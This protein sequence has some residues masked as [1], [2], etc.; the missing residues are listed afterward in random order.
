MQE[1]PTIKYLPGLE[2]LENKQL[3]STSHAARPLGKTALGWARRDPARTT[4]RVVR[5]LP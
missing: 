5:S 3:L 4:P 1:R 2:R